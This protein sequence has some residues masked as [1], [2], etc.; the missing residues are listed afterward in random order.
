MTKNPAPDKLT[1]EQIDSFLKGSQDYINGPGE[2]D[3]DLYVRQA[4]A[5][6][7]QLAD[8][9]H[10]NVRLR[11]FISDAIRY[12]EGDMPQSAYKILQ[13]SN[14]PIDKKCGLGHSQ[15]AFLCPACDEVFSPKTSE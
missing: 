3:I 7:C 15:P 2:I 8:T 13:Q 6:G 4:T 14:K 9:M 5:I 11:N 1:I 10:E 12:F